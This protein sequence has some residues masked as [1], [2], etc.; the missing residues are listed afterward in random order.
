MTSPEQWQARD[1]RTKVAGALR[2]EYSLGDGPERLFA[3]LEIHGEGLAVGAIAQVPTQLRDTVYGY[4]IF[5]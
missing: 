2:R 4:V 1:L 5:E 3:G